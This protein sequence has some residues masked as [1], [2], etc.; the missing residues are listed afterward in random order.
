M[1]SY[2]G[3]SFVGI[4]ALAGIFWFWVKKKRMGEVDLKPFPFGC[5]TYGGLKDVLDSARIF[6]CMLKQ[7]ALP[8][9]LR[10]WLCLAD[11]LQGLDCNDLDF[12]FEAA[13]GLCKWCEC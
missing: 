2:A 6:V 9:L 5:L 3:Y 7:G 1:A 10:V 12:P 11:M 4:H 13:G 8:L